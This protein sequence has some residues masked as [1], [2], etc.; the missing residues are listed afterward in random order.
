MVN[1][2][3]NRNRFILIIVALVSLLLIKCVQNLSGVETTNGA[4]ISV[5]AYKVEG[6]ASPFA[7]IYLCDNNYIPYIDSGTGVATAADKNGDFLI[8]EINGDKFSVS[9]VSRDNSGTAFFC[10]GCDSSTNQAT[11]SLPGKLEG[12]IVTSIPGSILVFLRGTGY[13]ILLES[14][15]PFVFDAIPQGTHQIQAAIISKGSNGSK[16]TIQ[17]LS[18]PVEVTVRPGSVVKASLLT[19]P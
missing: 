11:L 14:P 12:S 10:A 13:Y 5:M 2:M 17:S 18:S 6:T 1:N 4:T 16:S 19:I 3:I 9:I 15:G 7:F 8:N